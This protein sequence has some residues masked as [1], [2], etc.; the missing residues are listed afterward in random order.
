MQPTTIPHRRIGANGH[1]KEALFKSCGL[2]HT[3][4]EWRLRYETQV[5]RLLRPQPSA[6]SE[7]SQCVREPSDRSLGGCL[8]ASRSS[9]NGAN[10]SGLAN[11][12]Q[13][14]EARLPK[15]LIGFFRREAGSGPIGATGALGGAP[16]P[17]RVGNGRRQDYVVEQVPLDCNIAG[18]ACGSAWQPKTRGCARAGWR[19]SFSPIQRPLDAG[20]GMTT[21]PQGRTARNANKQSRACRSGFL[22]AV[23]RSA[24][25]GLARGP[26]QV[27]NTIHGR[28]SRGALRR[29]AAVAVNVW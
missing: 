7:H 21:E 1:L 13:R 19:R 25:P 6:R 5:V 27:P 14:G 18:L 3:P 8:W 10:D 26:G 17:S 22:L 28:R 23:P 20:R 24:A 4:S 15:D 29:N 16:E 9:C 2:L 11:L 12:V